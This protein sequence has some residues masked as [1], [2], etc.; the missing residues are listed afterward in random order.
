ML[1]RIILTITI[2]LSITYSSFSQNWQTPFERDSNQTA[3][4]TEG[5]AFYEKLAKAYPKNFRFK[6]VGKS[7]IGVPLHLGVISF[8]G[9][10]TPEV[11]RAKDKIVLFINNA[12][13]AGEP[14][15]VDATM[16][17]VRDILVKGKMR[18]S[19]KNIVL[20]F[21]PFYNVDGVRN[22]GVWQ[23]RINQNGPAVYGFR[24]NGQNLDLNR[25]FIKCDTRN[26]QTFNQTFAA[27]QPH[28]LIDNHSSNGADYQ[29]VMTLIATQ[30]DKLNPVLSELL[31]EKMSPFLYQQMAKR[32]FEMTP[33]VF[34]PDKL[35]NGIYTFLDLP[36]YSTGFATLHNCIGFMPE[37]HMLKPFPQR[38]RATHQFTET[39]ISF[40]FSH[41][42]DVK[43]ARKEADQMTR[44]TQINF[45]L[46]W[47]NDTAVRETVAFKGYEEGSKPSLVSGLPRLFY[48]RSKPFTRN[49]TFFTTVTP[50]IT[51]SKPRAYIVPQA[52]E[53]VVERLRWNGVKMTPLSIDTIIEANFY[54]ITDYKSTDKPY[55]G[56]HPNR[57]AVTVTK[58]LK[59]QFF[60]GDW[61]IECNQTVNNYIISTLEPRGADSF[62]AWNFFDGILNQKEGFS[63][64]VFEDVAAELLAKDPILQKKLE[65]KRAAESTFK[66]SAAAQL[67]FIYKNSPYYEPSHLLYPVAR[68]D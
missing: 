49:L 17:A 1:K 22:R 56:H 44:S 20:V 64:Y 32:G 55:E 61:L 52:Y 18:D 39:M 50:T 68:L 42:N 34:F 47:K 53:K 66:N 46:N 7:D 23:S 59:R 21:I 11:A 36:R 14:E 43:K 35:E 29:Y 63:D 33:Y 41:E 57:E 28:I 2:C 6:P 25:D 58:K 38:V 65:E 24:G 67:D 62:F 10:F 19:L 13:H 30:K 40:I 5:V 4:H 8:D 16:L 60:K 45:P 27:W 48:D 26:A 51:V 15:G 31:Q 3:S 9:V 54:Y 37:T 12:I